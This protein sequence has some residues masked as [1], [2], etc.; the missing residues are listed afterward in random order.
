MASKSKTP[1]HTMAT[2]DYRAIAR[3]SNGKP[4]RFEILKVSSAEEAETEL[5]FQVRNLRNVLLLVKA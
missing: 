5:R 1:T 3:D 4:M 2:R